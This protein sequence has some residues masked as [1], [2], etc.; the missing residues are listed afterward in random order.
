M[1]SINWSVK[2]LIRRASQY[3]S[4]LDVGCG[5]GN[6]IARVRAARRVGLDAAA[7]CVAWCRSHHR[8]QDVH[9]VQYDVRRICEL[10]DNDAFEC[11]YGMDI[12]E[13]LDKNGGLQLVHDCEVLASKCT[14]FFVPVGN[15]PQ[16]DDPCG[17]GNEHFQQHRSTW[18]PEDMERLGYDVYYYPDWHKNISPEK[19]K[20]AMWC[21][22]KLA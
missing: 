16:T 3:A 13:H 17:M 15:H 2:E 11:V 6:T 21:V 12:V 20:G 14:M 7:P 9:F 4:V 18:Y 8:D 19:S 1:E 10:F 5:K 22:K